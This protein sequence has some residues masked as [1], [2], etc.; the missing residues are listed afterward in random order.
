MQ[1]ENP[2]VRFEASFLVGSLLFLDFGRKQ[3]DSEKK[4][5]KSL[6]N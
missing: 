2:E 6:K 4:I 1:D 3:L 5:M